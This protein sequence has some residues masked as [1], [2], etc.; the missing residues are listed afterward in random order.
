MI[1]RSVRTKGD[2]MTLDPT[3]WRIGR[4]TAWLAAV[5][6]ALL[7]AGLCL[8]RQYGPSRLQPCA[9]DPALV[10]RII[11][12]TANAARAIRNGQGEA[13]LFEWRVAPDGSTHETRTDLVVSFSGDRFKLSAKDVYSRWTKPR[14]SIRGRVQ[15]AVTELLNL[16]YSNWLRDDR[17][18][19]FDG[20]RTTT[21][22]PSSGKAWVASADSGTRHHVLT[23]V[24]VVR[25]GTVAVHR[26]GT[27]R[28][29]DLGPMPFAITYSN[30]VVVGWQAVGGAGCVVVEQTQTVRFPSRPLTYEIRY[31]VCPSRGYSVLRGE[32]WLEH[33]AQLLQ[34]WDARV[35][36]CGQ[37]LWAPV[38]TE[39][40][41]FG[42]LGRGRHGA[43]HRRITTLDP[44]FQF[45]LPTSKLHLSLR[46]P[47][48]TKVHDEV[49][50]RDYVV[51]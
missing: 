6:A 5:A 21:F 24:P 48:G 26:P 42:D 2:G 4:R 18:V 13:G 30:P 46:L 50:K 40:I 41:Q 45:N 3:R 16:R 35:R 32:M 44:D 7:L 23:S 39:T 31:W 34:S 36:R 51:K 9:N 38:R 49:R 25:G 29:G 10:R 15:R 1:S 14:R 17:T 43:T 28:R 12:E 11:R 8:Y 27:T 33:R 37:A 19:C 47:R 20:K 22:R